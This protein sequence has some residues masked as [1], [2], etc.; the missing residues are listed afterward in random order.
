MRFFNCL[1][2]TVEGFTVRPAKKTGNKFQL[3][4]CTLPFLN[5]AIESWQRDILTTNPIVQ[6]FQTA[7]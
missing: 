5:A 4:T 6:K 1:Q 7:D 3:I 2:K